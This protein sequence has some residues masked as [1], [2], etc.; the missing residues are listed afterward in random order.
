MLAIDNEADDFDALHDAGEVIES[1][2]ERCR[3]SI[4]ARRKLANG[5]WMKGESGSVVVAH[6]LDDPRVFESVTQSLRCAP[7]DRAPWRAAC[8]R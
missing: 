8:R 5:I 6:G 1:L 3:A 7:G 4:R 2:L